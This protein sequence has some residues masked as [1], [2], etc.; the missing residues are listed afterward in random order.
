M[1]LIAVLLLVI[2]LWY[3]TVTPHEEQNDRSAFLTK[4]EGTL[5]KQ[6]NTLAVIHISSMRS[7]LASHSKTRSLFRGIEKG[8][9]EGFFLGFSK[10]SNVASKE[11]LSDEVHCGFGYERNAAW[12]SPPSILPDP[13]SE[14]RVPQ[15]NGVVLFIFVVQPRGEAPHFEHWL[16]CAENWSLAVQGIP[17]VVDYQFGLGEKCKDLEK[18]I[19]EIIHHH[20]QAFVDEA[21]KLKCVGSNNRPAP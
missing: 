8:N 15:K 9:L 20:L 13:S 6:I 7:E 17:V 2:V 16:P 3:V 19:K 4:L 12:A 11:V 10:N 14:F 5:F 18:P 1:V 21:Q